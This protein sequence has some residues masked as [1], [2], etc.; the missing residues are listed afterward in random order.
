[1]AHTFAEHERVARGL[2]DRV[3]LVTGGT[4]PA[5]HVHPTVVDAMADV[6]LDLRDRIP[7]AVTFEALQ[8]SDLVVTMGCSASDVCPA[9]WVGESR[10]WD[11]EDPA[12]KPAVAVAS[13]RDEIERRVAELFD[14]LETGIDRR[15]RHTQ[16]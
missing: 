10:D 12:G 13:I 16:R 1:M 4:R 15:E 9:G 8:G 14:E 6:G 3:E 7:R 11:L 2:E 5:D